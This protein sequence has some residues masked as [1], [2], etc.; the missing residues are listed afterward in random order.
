MAAYDTLPRDARLNIDADFLAT[1]YRLHG[2]AKSSCHIDH[3]PEQRISISIQGVRLTSQIDSCI[4]YHVNGYHLKQ[5][6]LDR[7][8]WDKDT[9]NSIDFGLFGQHIRT[10]SQ[11]G[12]W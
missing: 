4:R 10:S 7:K 12:F 3:Y 11:G 2:K 5:Y 1:R 9:W 6:M 8:K